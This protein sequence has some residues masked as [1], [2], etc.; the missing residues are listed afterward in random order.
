MIKMKRCT[1][2]M[3]EVHNDRHS[4]SEVYNVKG[5][6]RSMNMYKRIQLPECQHKKGTM[7]KLVKPNM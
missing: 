6:M 1:I 3:L 5:K 2:I 7:I 4:V